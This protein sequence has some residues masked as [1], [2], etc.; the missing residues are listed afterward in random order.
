LNNIE[1][2]WRVS[3]A[4]ASFYLRAAIRPPPAKSRCSPLSGFFPTTNLFAAFND[5][6]R[7]CEQLRAVM[8]KA[9]ALAESHLLSDVRRRAAA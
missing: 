3:G 7:G 4:S 6:C 8:F 1:R 9:R 2:E 5:T